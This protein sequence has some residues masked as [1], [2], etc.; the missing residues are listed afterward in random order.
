LGTGGS[1]DAALTLLLALFVFNTGENLMRPWLVGD[2][3]K[4]PTFVVFIASAVG[5]LLAGALGAI[6]AIPLVAM[7]GEALR[8]FLDG[9]TETNAA[10]PETALTD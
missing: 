7:A 9:D 6:V 3:M 8:I 5:V 1:G 2:S 10:R 4:M